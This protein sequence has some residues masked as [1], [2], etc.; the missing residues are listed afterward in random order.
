[1]FSVIVD[2]GDG[3]DGCGDE[4]DDEGVIKLKWYI[5]TKRQRFLKRHACKMERLHCFK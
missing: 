2:D 1:M 4:D 5:G 3:V